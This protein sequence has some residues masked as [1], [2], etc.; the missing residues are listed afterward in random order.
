MKKSLENWYFA[1]INFHCHAYVFGLEHYKIHMTKQA[2]FDIG[3]RLTLT[4]T[5]G[6]TISG[7]SRNSTQK[8]TS[9]ATT[10]E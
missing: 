6:H 2:K 1:D 7:Y 8:N 9:F 3:L 4:T 10:I 5:T